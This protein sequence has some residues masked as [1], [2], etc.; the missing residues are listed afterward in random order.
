MSLL[1]GKLITP[2]VRAN[3]HKF[4]SGCEISEKKKNKQTDK[5]HNSSEET[6]HQDVTEGVQISLLRGASV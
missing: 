5:T 3:F 6:E 4:S 1:L 2:N